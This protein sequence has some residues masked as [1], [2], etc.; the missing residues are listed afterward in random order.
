LKRAI[1]RFRVFPL[2]SLI[3]SGQIEQGDLVKIDQAPESRDLRFSKETQGALVGA[4]AM[5]DAGS[6]EPRYE[7]QT[8][9]A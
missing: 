4:P 9:A 1:E 6:D 3:A 8:L 5:D 7:C 2:A